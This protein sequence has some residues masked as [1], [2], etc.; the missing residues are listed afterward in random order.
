MAAFTVLFT[1]LVI[2]VAELIPK[3][4]GERFAAPVALYAAPCITFV[5][6]LLLPLIWAVEKLNLPFARRSELQVGSEEEI[7]VLANVGNKAGAISPQESELIRKAF[8]LND[9]TAKDIMTH[10]LKVCQLPTEKPLSE[11]ESSRE[12]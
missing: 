9:M 7:R 6:R 1:L 8:L 2:V 10:R 5:E 11:L 4:I 3:T 12:E